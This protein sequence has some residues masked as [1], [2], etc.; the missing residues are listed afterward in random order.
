MQR[1]PAA[2]LSSFIQLFMRPPLP[3]VPRS[4]CCT[5][6]PIFPPELRRRAPAEL[7]LPGPRCA[8]YRPLTLERLLE[9]KAVHPDAKL[10][11]GNTGG[12]EETGMGP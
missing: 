9:I 6:E 12:P 5:V 8:W 7:A 10:V 2:L 3:H 4:A 1:W 11:V